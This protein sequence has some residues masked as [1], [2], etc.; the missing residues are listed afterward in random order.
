[1][2]TTPRIIKTSNISTEISNESIQNS[3]LIQTIICVILIALVIGLS[4][5]THHKFVRK[6]GCFKIQE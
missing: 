1:M 3:N 6:I 5:I 2:Y 4:L